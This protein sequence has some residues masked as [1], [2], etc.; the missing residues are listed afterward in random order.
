MI[1]A[2]DAATVSRMT[3]ELPD[4]ANVTPGELATACRAAIEECDARIAALIA[5]PGGR[6]TFENTVLAAEEA[7]AAVKEA[8]AAWGLLAE[9]SP[10]QGLREAAQEWGARLD[11][12][13]VGIGLDERVF[14][15]VREY[16]D[17]AEAAALA[18][19]DARLLGDVQRDYRRSGVGLPAAQRERLQAL[20]DEL[21]ELG[22]GFAA[23]LASW[24]DGI[25]VERDELAGLPEAYVE[26]LERVGDGYRV[27][28]DNP[29]FWPFMCEA[30]SAE[31]RRE[32]LEKDLRK[33]G[34]ENVAR[35]ERALAVRGEIAGMLGYSSWAAYVLETRMAK[36]P[37]AV[38]AF[39]DDL[40]ARLAPK[41]AADLAEMADA[42][43]QAGGSREMSQWEQPYAISRLKQ[44]RY[45][46]DDAEITQYLPLEACLQGLFAT[47]GTV[48]GIRFEEV[49]DASV[50][51]PEV[52]TFDVRDARNT[53][54]LGNA[55]NVNEAAD[56]APFARFHLDLFPRPD[57]YKHAMALPLRPGR[58][59]ADGSWQ[60]PVAVMLTNLTRPSTDAP[61]LLRHSELVTLFHE[62]GHVLHEILA[63]A[64]HPRYSGAETEID[65]VEAPSQ[66]L[67]H[68]CWEPTVVGSFARHHRTGEPIP[69][70]LLA[71]LAAA[72]TAASGVLTME[73]LALATL[74]AAYHSA[75]YSQRSGGSTATYAEVYARHGQA[76]LAGTHLQSG[77]THLFGYDAAYYSY[78]WSKVLGDDMYTRFQQ[79]GP[80]DPTTGAHYRRT[81]L[82]PGGTVDGAAMVREFLGREPSNDA[83]L[84][85]IG[86]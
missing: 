22:S 71:G 43:E 8:R 14:R 32:L 65:F 42:N 39:L 15:A 78:L 74:D 35:L 72:K 69:K 21:V 55:G 62:F 18:G 34:A 7:R 11:K 70:H 9:V 68:W 17:G 60:Q 33:G 38:A 6:R 76:Y 80:L 45:A 28:L 84:R 73:Q 46:F 3:R 44:T 40:R 75:E 77:I 58:R 66:M 31:R 57:K 53:G 86:L 63:R 59:L 49:S 12:R 26:G 29:E 51:H 82:E 67:E 83:F 79:A 56:G 13:S 36:T 50:W 16:A 81:V 24:R 27:S 20:L 19:V 4:Y 37:E 10:D 85:D 48:L 5:V 54:D 2:I 52:R 61:S 47:A 41:A 64:E 25:V 30:R 23:T 1:A